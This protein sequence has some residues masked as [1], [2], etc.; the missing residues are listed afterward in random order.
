MPREDQPVVRSSEEARRIWTAYTSVD[1][2]ENFHPLTPP[3]PS[4]PY[5]ANIYRP[6]ERLGSSPHLPPHLTPLK[7]PSPMLPYQR[8]IR[9][10]KLSDSRDIER[11]LYREA[12]REVESNGV[13]EIGTLQAEMKRLKRQR[14]LLLRQNVVMAKCMER[15]VALQ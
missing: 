6:T 11:N 5:V 13:E 4:R 7:L 3:P 15:M 14:D 8:Q 1:V 9:P 2:D 12:L 10:W